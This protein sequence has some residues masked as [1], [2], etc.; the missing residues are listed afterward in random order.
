MKKRI[1]V[2]M[3]F[4]STAFVA[5]GGSSTEA[6]P[7][8]E[9]G[10]CSAVNEGAV[11]WLE[12]E[13][14]GYICSMGEWKV[15]N[16]AGIVNSAGVVKKGSVKDSRD[17][18]TYSTVTFDGVT[19]FAQNLNYAI[20]NTD[21]VDSKCY[22]ADEAN[23]KKYGR[24]YSRAA[25]N[26]P[27]ICPEN[28]TVIDAGMWNYL[29]SNYMGQVLKSTTGWTY[30]NDAINP[31]NSKGLSLDPT[32]YCTSY[33]N[34]SAIEYEGRF[35]AGD[36]NYVAA[37]YDQNS[38]AVLDGATAK[39][40]YAIRCASFNAGTCNG[41]I[42]AGSVASV[43]GN[44]YVCDGGKWTNANH[45]GEGKVYTFQN[46]GN[47]AIR[48]GSLTDPRD[49]NVYRTVVIGGKTWMAENLRYAGVDGRRVCMSDIDVNC[50]IGG[51]LYYGGEKPCPAGWHVP[52][53]EEFE[54]LLAA[55]GP[56]GATALRA[57][58]GWAENG[59][60]ALG[61][62]ALPA[63]SI[64]DGYGFLNGATFMT[65]SEVLEWDDDHVEIIDQD[66]LFASIGIDSEI[67]FY[68]ANLVAGSV[69]CVMD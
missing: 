54:A 34:C 33:D 49:G 16:Q 57:S 18:K 61:F 8:E 28:F 9:L 62:S 29:T 4:A 37:Y 3:S 7:K 21:S 32:G 38:L 15:E 26:L 44:T 20:A 10:V 27:N 11:V 45:Y 59:T 53:K 39:D 19:W 35:W 55:A 48:Y 51:A 12:T 36:A 58:Q 50:L 1:L 56:A 67:D 31:T 5:C 43:L 25:A 64:S 30:W 41:A 46:I 66:Y 63:G 65:S 24:L 22:G 47:P 40:H 60:D 6:V 13:N 2:C 23:C 69:R 42:G 14:K 68:K 52:S 17:G